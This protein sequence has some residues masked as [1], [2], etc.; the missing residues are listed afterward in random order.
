M[1]IRDPRPDDEAGWRRLWIGYTSF[2][3]TKVPEAVT[4]ATWRRVLDPSAA[5][6]GRLAEQ[7]GELVGFCLCVPHDATWS[8]APVCYLEDLFVARQ[9]RKSGIGSALI[10][11]VLALGRKHGWSRVYW[12]T[13]ANNRTARKLYDS[14]AP[15]DNFVRYRLTLPQG[16]E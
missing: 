14:F 4:A 13:Q 9:A 5:M 16:R 6:F 15:A 2:Y 10:E 12:H 11:D 3:Q 7:Q 8:E 1:L